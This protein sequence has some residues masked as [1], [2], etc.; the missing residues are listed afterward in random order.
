MAGRFDAALK[1]L[2]RS[3]EL[4]RKLD[5]DEPS[6]FMS[7]GNLLIGMI[8]D[9]QGKRQDAMQQYKKVL[10]MKEYEDSHKE[11]KKYLEKSYTHN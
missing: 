6:G 7:L 2:Y 4:S 9:A 5:K 8:Y 3:D 1:S 10:A 11:S